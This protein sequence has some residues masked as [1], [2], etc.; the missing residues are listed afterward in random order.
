MDLFWLMYPPTQ[1]DHHWNIQLQYLPHPIKRQA[2]VSDYEWD[3]YILWDHNWVQ[4][5]CKKTHVLVIFQWCT[6]WKHFRCNMEK[7]LWNNGLSSCG[8]EHKDHMM[9]QFLRLGWAFL[10]SDHKKSYQ[11]RNE[12]QWVTAWAHA[13]H[14]MI[15]RVAIN[16]DKEKKIFTIIIRLHLRFY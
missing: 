11:F 10:S 7:S 3:F 4:L 9:T 15:Y 6:Q 1:R 12:C 16:C 13:R 5:C 14:V 2:T 8:W